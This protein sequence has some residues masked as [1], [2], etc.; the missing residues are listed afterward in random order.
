M[1]L[2]VLL[3]V[4]LIGLGLIH[5]NWVIGG[6]FGFSESLPTKLNGEKLLNPKK[7]DSA[8]VGIGLTAFGF[9]YLI[10]SGLININLP[11]WI[12]TYGSWIIPII[13]LLRAIGDFKYVGFFKQIKETEFGKWD[14]KL[15]SPLCLII[16]LFGTI[17]QLTL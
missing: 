8:V 5:F 15:F 6:K 10:K 3:S 9:F 13:F 2:S 17:I 14:T 16:A 4:I 7:K 12:M 1:I 11:L